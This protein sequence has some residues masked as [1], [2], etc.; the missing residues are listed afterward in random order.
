MPISCEA[1]ILLRNQVI[2][3]TVVMGKSPSNIA[4]ALKR[5]PTEDTRTFAQC[6]CALGL[7]VFSN[8]S[9]NN[10][11]FPL[12]DVHLSSIR[13]LCTSAN[14]IALVFIA[15]TSVWRPR[16]LKA[17][18]FLFAAIAGSALGP[19]TIYAGNVFGSLPVLT[20]GACATSI[21]RGICTIFV[22]L[23]L[24]KLSDKRALACI[25]L[26]E[27]GATAA[28]LVFPTGYSTIMLVMHA[29]CLIAI[30]G[31]SYP[32]AQHVLVKLGEKP[33]PHDEAIT[34]PSSY[35]PFNHQIFMCFLLFRIVYGFMLTFGEIGGIPANSLWSL[36][37]FAIA[38]AFIVGKAGWITADRL[39]RIALLLS[40]AGFLLVPA[41]QLVRF[42]VPN[43][44]ISSG[45]AVFEVFNWIVLCSLA[46]RNT[47]GAVSVFAWGFALNAI[48]VIIGANAGRFTNQYWHDDSQ[49][50]IIVVAA[51]TFALVAYV[52]AVL[53][54]FSFDKAIS[55]VHES[56][57]PKT[58][59]EADSV[60]ESTI[61]ER[62]ET[63][64]REYSLTKREEEVLK[65]LARGRTGVFIQSELC[66]SYNTIKAHVKHI[67]T[68]LDV[69]THQELIDLV[70]SL[71]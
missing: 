61:Y 26:A 41:S 40:I 24:C 36:V 63:L 15:I 52:I 9:L 12:Y 69:H 11:L 30:I 39:F 62:C 35:V 58:T 48:G 22:G 28:S 57:A 18:F 4:R 56:V 59:L 71:S 29:A 49:V 42:S 32:A 53:R 38:F 25:V 19:I 6:L 17:R 37:V 16:I 8:W 21:A 14:G 67:Y 23:L 70:E 50:V 13:E 54:D 43:G 46:R 64:V 3:Y 20:A 5:G 7:L 68:K 27:L 55:E 45:I 60:T 51:I 47:H 31:L 1:A 34:Q 2:K 44:L 65:L 66:V 10:H 33:S